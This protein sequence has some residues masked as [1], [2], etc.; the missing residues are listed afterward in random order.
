MQVVDSPANAGVN[1]TKTFNLVL[2]I[3]VGSSTWWL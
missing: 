1:R 3:I 2:L